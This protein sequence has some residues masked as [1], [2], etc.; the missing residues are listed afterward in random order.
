M[1]RAHFA[2]H[3]FI[4]LAE[5][6]PPLAVPEHDVTDEQ[7]AQH[8]RADLAGERAGAFPMHILRADFDMLRLAERAVYRRDR[9]EWRNDHYFHLGGFAQLQKEGGDEAGRLALS[10]VH[11]PIRGD[12]FFSHG[13]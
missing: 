4:R 5:E 10:H 6:R 13:S 12:D 8:R 1:R 9:G 3:D 7:I 11:L 2:V